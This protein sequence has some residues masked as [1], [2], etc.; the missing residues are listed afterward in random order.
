MKLNPPSK[1]T[2]TIAIMEL[3]IPFTFLVFL[4]A[5]FYFFTKLRTS[6]NHNLPPQPWKL[7]LLGHLHHLAGSIPNR[8]L[9]KLADKL[10]PIIH[11]QLGQINTVVISSPDL[12]KDIMK[13]NDTT[14]ATRPKLLAAEI[15]AYNYKDIAFS[16]YGDY[17][18]QMRKICVLELLSAKKVESFQSIRDQESWNVV[19]HMLKKGPQPIN[20]SEMISNMINVIVFTVS[21][22]SGCKDQ[23]KYLELTEESMTLSSGFDVADLFPSVT[24][25]HL[26]V[27]TRKKLLK[28]HREMDKV[29]DRIISDREECRA[30]GQTDYNDL[31]EVLLKLKDDDDGLQFPLNY[32]NVKAVLSDMFAAGTDTSSVTIEWTFFELMKNPKIMN[33]VQAELRHV[34]KGKK[35]IYES[36]IKELTYLKLVIKETLRLHAPLPLLL[37]R[38]CQKNSKIGGY[39][40]PTNTKVIINYWKIGR[41]P[42][43]WD[44]PESFIPERFSESLIDFK[45]TNFEYTPFGAGRRICPGMN[46][47]L[48]NIELPLARLLYHFNWELPN[49][50]KIEV[51][52]GTESF[53]ATLKLKNNLLLLPRAYDTN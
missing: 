31:L 24:P 51:L 5:L 30:N 21:I 47:G 40:I 50:A 18:R 32:D 43:N 14:F 35:K 27:G 13:T 36:D 26:V 17:W 8:A 16:P 29:L 12:A 6:P 20:L 48:A 39:D 1:T 28:I 52:D 22:G 53:G 4:L 2:E 11:L 33:K 19:E 49:G 9:G 10:G 44:D 15:M 3:Q 46:L 37:P 38:E 45:G 25:L 41:D 7:P 42:K 23:A 34:L